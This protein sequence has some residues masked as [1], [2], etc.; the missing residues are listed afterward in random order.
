MDLV[1]EEQRA[2]APCAAGRAPPRRPSSDRRRRRRSPRSAR[3]RDPVAP[4]SS[5][6]TVVL[7]VPGGPQKIRRAERARGEQPRQRAVRPE[8]MVL[9]DDLGEALSGAAGRPAG[10]ARRGRGRRR[11]RGRVISAAEDRGDLL[12]VAVDGDPPDRA[13]LA[14]TIC[15]ERLGVGRSL[16]AVDGEDD[17][18]S[19]G[20]RA[21]PPATS[22]STS[23]TTTPV[24]VELRCPASSATRRRQI[25][26]GRAGQRRAARRAWPRRAA[27]SRARR[28]SA[29][30]RRRA[31]RRAGRR[32]GRLPPSGLVAKR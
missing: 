7:P 27:A 2:P 18:A 32:A 25:G 1:D 29:I 26:D 6:A 22:A 9:P 12:P 13:R 31:C 16:L 3:R 14:A 28:P 20:S 5:R 19:S 23:T 4:A 30:A 10:A 24:G 15:A 17:V 8:Q 21:R 11:R